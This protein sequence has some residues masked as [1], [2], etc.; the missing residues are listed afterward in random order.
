MVPAWASSDTGVGQQATRAKI[1]K[2][3]RYYDAVADCKGRKLSCNITKTITE[4]AQF[5]GW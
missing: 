3:A 5:D 1:R 2:A 4:I